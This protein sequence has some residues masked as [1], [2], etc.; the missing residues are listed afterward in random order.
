VIDMRGR[1]SLFV[2]ALATVSV[3]S[4]VPA[5]R[6]NEVTEARSRANGAAGELAA[7][8]AR[9]AE[10]E[11]EIADLERL[12]ADARRRIA[13][14][15]GEIEKMA[16]DEFIHGR[17]DGPVVATDDLQRAAMA[18]ALAR[19]VTGDVRAT[20]DEYRAASDDLA[21][22]EE[23]LTASRA[24][25][26]EAVVT[27]EAVE[28]E[29]R[30]ELQRVAEAA[31]LRAARPSRSG[32]TGA[33]GQVVVLGGDRDWL[34][35]VRGP[36][37]FTNDWGMPRSGGRR[38]QGNDI[39]SPRG[40]P[41]VASVSGTVRIHNSSLGGLSYYLTGDDGNQYFGTHLDSVTGVSGRVEQ[42]TVVGYVGDSGN[43]R[44]G[45]THL[46]FEIKPGSGAPINPYP[47]VAAN[48]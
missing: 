13:A 20:V 4:A 29:A 42:G 31:R 5:V 33:G 45:P 2:A 1:T 17:T 38:H 12:Q 44:G 22:A 7:A 36:T 34:C 32:G 43:A 23:Q 15:A 24:E 8:K 18:E 48:C 14:V 30:V 3:V 41:V 11:V 10:L 25:A 16:V 27:L 9:L 6:A 35:P 26:G 37:S 47:T 46:H 28:L 40:T 19:V 21:W 39:L